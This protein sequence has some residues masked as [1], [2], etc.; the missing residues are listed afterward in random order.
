MKELEPGIESVVP[1]VAEGRA[2][3]TSGFSELRSAPCVLCQAAYW[4]WYGASISI[5]WLARRGP[6]ALG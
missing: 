2:C 4:L 6:N 3:R 5:R 1:T